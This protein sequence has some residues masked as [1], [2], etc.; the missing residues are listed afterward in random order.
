MARRARKRVGIRERFVASPSSA[1]TEGEKGSFSDLGHIL[2]DSK[3]LEIFYAMKQATRRPL[4]RAGAYCGFQRESVQVFVEHF[5]LSSNCSSSPSS[6]SS[7]IAFI[8]R[9]TIALFS[10]SL[11]NC[12]YPR[13]RVMLRF[14]DRLFEDDDRGAL[15]TGHCKDATTASASTSTSTI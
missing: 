8:G 9:G 3:L 13:Y 1:S 4:A 14:P 6:I 7:H 2:R 12:T 5:Q 11:R 10:Q 15:C